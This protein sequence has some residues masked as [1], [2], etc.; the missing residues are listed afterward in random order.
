MIEIEH[1]LKHTLVDVVQGQG[2]HAET[3]QVVLNRI[4]ELK[5]RRVG[6]RF[7]KKTFLLSFAIFAV[8]A[9]GTVSAASQL[10]PKP[11]LKNEMFSIGSVSVVIDQIPQSDE[12]SVHYPS[13]KNGSADARMK[14]I[15]PQTIVTLERLQ[16][17]SPISFKLPTNMP[18]GY[19]FAQDEPKEGVVQWTAATDAVEWVKDGRFSYT[20]IYNVS[21]ENAPIRVSYDFDPKILKENTV[22]GYADPSA[23]A[24][25]I[26]SYD[27][28]QLSTMTALF[29]ELPGELLLTL[30][31]ETPEQVLASERVKILQSVID[32][33]PE[34]K[35]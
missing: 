23:V 2:P 18:D 29:I 21:D 22:L 4:G 20:A 5:G 15:E 3:K 17:L 9:V 19:T 35:P 8:L 11:F 10:K 24:I 14:E 26:G 33:I 30:S 7:S 34:L 6:H 25:K 1:E 32:Q 27:A 31:V 13:L 16:S 12:P 28:V